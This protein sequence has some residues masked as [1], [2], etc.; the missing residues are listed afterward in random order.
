VVAGKDN[1]VSNRI[2]YY[3]EKAMRV[4]FVFTVGILFFGLGHGLTQAGTSRVVPGK[5]K[6]KDSTIPFEDAGKPKGN[7][8]PFTF[9]VPISEKARK[10]TPSL[11]I[12]QLNVR[13]E[14]T[15][16]GAN[17]TVTGVYH[18]YSFQTI[19][20]ATYSIQ[21][22]DNRGGTW[23]Q[24]KGGPL[25]P[26]PA[27]TGGYAAV[28]VRLNNSLSKFRFV[29]TP[30]LDDPKEYRMHYWTVLWRCEKLQLEKFGATVGNEQNYLNSLGFHTELSLDRGGWLFYEAP[31]W[32]EWA[33]ATLGDAQFFQGNMPKGVESS[34]QEH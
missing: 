28:E 16:M 24:I 23:T 22:Q 14:R 27:G 6:A 33:F 9:S 34:I 1:H 18:N 29:V 5:H 3:Q 26:I 25:P 31:G 12:D 2:G 10:P 30:S 13:T 4:S 15:G 20:G 21:E 32:R 19:T 8:D 11:S 17:L 7:T